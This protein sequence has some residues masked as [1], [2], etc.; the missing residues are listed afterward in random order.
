[1]GFISDMFKT[2]S[3][4]VLSQPKPI[5]IVDSATSR[6]AKRRSIARQ[7]KRSGRASTIL[8]EDKLGG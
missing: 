1:M 6:K 4:P 5:P 2:P 3:M 8:T 7:Q